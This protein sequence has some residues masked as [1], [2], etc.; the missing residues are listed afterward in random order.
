MQSYRV[1]NEIT[2]LRDFAREFRARFRRLHLRKGASLLELGSFVGDSTRIFIEEIS[3]SQV[4]CVDPWN[5]LMPGYDVEGNNVLAAFQKNVLPVAQERR[6]ELYAV[7]KTSDEFFASVTDCN[8]SFDLVYIDA[9]HTY[10]A[11]MS[12]IRGS[13]PML[14]AGGTLA[15][16]DY[17]PRHHPGVV[18]AA[19]QAHGELD[20]RFYKLEVFADTTWAL[21]PKGSN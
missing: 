16:H 13:L 21:I 3:P 18:E 17:S 1:G 14:K 2:G 15:G 8:D 19:N 9:I 7:P 4:V 10:E 20:G 11:V 5:Q 6:C 12:D